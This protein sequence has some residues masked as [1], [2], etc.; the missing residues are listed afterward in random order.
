MKKLKKEMETSVNNKIDK[1]K[2]EVKTTLETAVAKVA[3]DTKNMVEA[4]MEKMEQQTAHLQNMVKENANNLQ[5]DFKEQTGKM[6]EMFTT[7]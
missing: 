4:Q 2:K 7:M 1:M 3:E 6:L 5:S